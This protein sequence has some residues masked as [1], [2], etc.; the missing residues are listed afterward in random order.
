MH[1]A[2]ASN[3]GIRIFIQAPPTVSANT[4]VLVSINAPVPA[5]EP[6]PVPASEPT[7]MLE[8]RPRAPS[9]VQ[10]V[11]PQ[12]VPATYL[13]PRMEPVA[14]F[15]GMQSQAEVNENRGCIYK[16]P[17]RLR[18]VNEKAYEPNV[19]S[20]G[21]YHHGKQHLK[22]MQVIKRSFFL[23][24]A[25]ENNL[26]V[27]ELAR[28][29]RSLEARI[30][31]C[32]EE[33][34]FYLDSNQLVEMML[35]DGCFIVQLIQ[36]IHPAEDIFQVGRIQTDIRHDLLLL[37][38]QLPFFVLFE[39]YRMTVPNAGGDVHHL[40]RSALAL[41]DIFPCPLP[42][43]DIMYLVDLAHSCLYPSPLGIKQHEL[44]KAKA[45]AAAAEPNSQRSWKFIRSATELEGAGISFF[46]DHIEKMMDQNHG[47]ESDF[48]IMFSKDTK[49]LKIPT[50][51]V[52][53]WTEPLF[54]NYMAYEQF[55]P[56]GKPT[57]FVD[58]V[59]FMDNLINT[60]KEVQLLC[61]S[62]VI[63]NWLGDDEAVA[64]MFNK[65]RDSIYMS[66]D[67]Y[68]AEIFGRVNEHCQRKWN[69]WKAALK[70][71]Y[72]NTPWSLISFLAALVLLLLTL[73]QTI[74]SVLSYVKQ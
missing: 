4:P 8:P 74:F 5:S 11:V 12:S 30:R 63:D 14:P 31:K 38:N 48:D 33:A 24:I 71:N 60:G 55:F 61:K 29:M 73:L 67:F 23:K 68:Y 19:V 28:T 2:M 53:D 20:I 40:A 65:L 25:E 52:H 50:L 17:R 72:F 43:T 66:E 6:A 13:T 16:V 56:R 10:E 27:N 41:F 46:G 59:V 3:D 7:P 57:Y 32:Y 44:F 62:G 54:R 21:P 42:K 22:A 69:K 58:Y 45:A 64:L 37:E 1:L 39:L 15:R 26:N 18:E 35:L 34:A 9:Q 47:I 70:K 36:G 51:Q 49:V